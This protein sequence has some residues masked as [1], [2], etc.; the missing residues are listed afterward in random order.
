MTR[1]RP[2]R[3]ALGRNPFLAAGPAVPIART[4]EEIAAPP[5]TRCTLGAMGRLFRNPW[6]RALLIWTAILAVPVISLLPE[7]M[8]PLPPCNH[9]GVVNPDPT[10]PTC[11]PD[12]ANYE[13]IGASLLVLLWLAVA[14]IGLAAFVLTR[15]L[16][17]RQQAT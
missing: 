11:P 3:G 7:A 8:T 9:H 15:F 16:R 14:S 6:L 10:L 2:R 1:A 4:C 12:D 5:E 17:W 13:A